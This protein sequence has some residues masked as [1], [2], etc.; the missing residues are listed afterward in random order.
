M[1][2]KR[3]GAKG[4]AT[5]SRRV[6][7]P[8]EQP[9]RRQKKRASAK[10]RP[11]R[12]RL[13]LWSLKWGLALSIWAA[14]ALAGLVA[15]YAAG[16]PDVSGL[17]AMTRRPSV[18][19]LAADGATL[20]T[21]GGL[22]GEPV[23]VADLPPYLPQAV[24]A[25][26]DRRF[27]RHFG[28]DPLGLARAAVANVRAGRIVQG[29]ST[30]TQQL[31]KNLFLSPERTLK[32]KIQETLLAFWLERKFT[33]DQILSIYLNRVYLGAGAYG[34]DAAAREY[35]DKPASRVSLYE[36]ALLAGLLKAPSRYAPT[37][38]AD[39]ARGR[40]RLVLASMVEAGYIT[41]A[42]AKQ[43][44]ANPARFAPGRGGE[45]GRYFADW[46]VDQLS[47]FVGQVDRDL[48]VATTLDPKLQRIAEA[49]VEAMLAGPGEAAGV[50]Q[51]AL[52]VLSAQGPV[53][54]MV[55]GRDY[56]AS[57]F[58]RATQALRQPGS[59]FKLF[60]YLA[61]LERG[62]GPEERMADAPL[63]VAGW[64][65]RNYDGKYLG[66]MSLERALALSRNTVAVRVAE[67]VGRERVVA[68]ARR[69]GI[70]TRLEAR[71]S[72]ALGAAQVTLIEL[73]AAYAALANDGVGVWA[74]G[75]AEVRD[76]GGQVLYR[77]RGSGPGRL[78]A[79]D[80]VA[81]MNGMLAQVIADGT[82]KAAALDRPAAGKT[83]TSQDFRDAWFVG[84]T[85]D[86]VAGVWLGNDD[87][88]PMKRVTGGRLPAKLWRAV[89]A[90]AHEGRPARPLPGAPEGPK[91]LP[92]PEKVVAGDGAE[93]PTPGFWDELLKNLGIGE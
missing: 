64:S 75:I 55:G 60:V 7:V 47:D 5:T 22:Y 82:G 92:P 90:E 21:F 2:A 56:A 88:T 62:L 31:A 43:A 59:A 13:L 40:A 51:A 28:I 79:P 45:G 73:T 46:V 77:R 81:A 42:Q 48:V 35:F 74:H 49:E 11:L 54:A 89:M 80:H 67:R 68:L 9:R 39:L 8:S 70:T 78:I 44:R 71:P 32:R 20:A 66:R 85:A 87:E 3:K 1:I 4:S 19:V 10:R 41:E 58:N 6:D 76:R 63:T 14:V 12:R 86:L 23:G 34:V 26:E 27:Y 29:G 16:L 15:Y 37:E 61:A 83:G 36:A 53:R 57:Q 93:R 91:A 72:L 18:T 17:D 33:K 65:P 84:F 24:L 50:G 52:V 38:A 69:L 25:T 30:I